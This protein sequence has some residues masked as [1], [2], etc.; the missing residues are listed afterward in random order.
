M[1]KM[2]KRLSKAQK[3]HLFWEKNIHSQRGKFS[4]RTFPRRAFLH[5]GV[6]A[7]D[8]VD[9]LSGKQVFADIYNISGSHSYQQVPVDTIF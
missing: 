4:V 6:L 8:N 9:K 5:I 3:Y 7:V 2:C 1:W